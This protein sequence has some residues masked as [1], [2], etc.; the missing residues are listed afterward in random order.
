MQTILVLFRKYRKRLDE[1]ALA[2]KADI[3]NAGEVEIHVEPKIWTDNDLA[4]ILRDIKCLLERFASNHSLDPLLHIFSIFMDDIVASLF[5]PGLESYLADVGKWFDQ[6]L[7]DSDYVTSSVG[8]SV[9]EGLYDRGKKLTAEDTKFGKEI[10]EI[11]D[12][13]DSFLDALKSDRSGQRWVGS[14]DELSRDFTSLYQNYPAQVIEELKRDVFGWFLP[15]LLRLLR[16]IPMPRIEFVNNTLEVAVDALFLTTT[17]TISSLMPD[18]ICFESRSELHMDVSEDMVRKDR[19][20]IHVDGL[21]LAAKDL[22]YYVCYK[23][24]IFGYED[25]GL[26]SIFIGSKAGQGL[27]FD[28]DLEVDVDVGNEDVEA[29]FRTRDVRASITGLRFSIS[30]S[31]HQIINKLFVQPFAGPIVCKLFENIVSHHIRTRLDAFSQFAVDVQK[32]AKEFALDGS[33]PAFEHY[34]RAVLR[35]WDSSE[36]E[37]DDDSRPSSP[38]PTVHT[39]PTMTGVIQTTILEHTGSS[40]TQSQ[41]ETSLAIGMGPQILPDKGLVALE[42]NAPKGIAGRDALSE[43]VEDAV[44]RVQSKTQRVISE[45]ASG[46]KA[47][48]NGR[49]TLRGITER[50]AQRKKA[51]RQNAGWRSAAF[52]LQRFVRPPAGNECVVLNKN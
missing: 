38:G 18:H 36:E 16:A 52:D 11:F 15:R 7:K 23:G 34:W 10:R 45:A 3:A 41:Q 33:P 21:R 24:G 14:V 49:R 43:Q 47:N 22:G 1:I 50:V 40:A 44:D 27:A 30:R 5:E 42:E 19:R 28:A 32:E 6:A 8:K 51:E 39:Q 20:R 48:V 17:S 9:L 26:L 4:I 25:E 31:K 35:Q 13:L 29:L 12:T 2:A 37:H 46:A